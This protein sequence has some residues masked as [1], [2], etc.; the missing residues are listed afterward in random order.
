MRKL[1]LAGVAALAL[2]AAAPAALAQDNTAGAAA[3]AGTGA[4][5]GFIFGGPIGAV[6]GGFSGAVIGSSVSDAAITYA[7]NHPVDHVYV[8][9]DIDVGYK[10]SGGIKVYPIEGDE[11]HG[12]F[13][14]N[15]RVWIV[16]MATGEVVASPGY[17]V[18]EKAVA[19][20]KA[21]PTASI[22][23]SG[24]VSPGF[25]LDSGVTLADVPDAHGYAYAY[26][27]DQP[28]LVDSR[29]RIVIWVG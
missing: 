22:E 14:A 20:V 11:A 18:P 24:D 21:N 7:G 12:Y 10:V 26:I 8:D 1:L 5:L 4:T 23:I 3:G 16:D 19:Y 9:D 28:V 25:V 13:Y 27:G 6:I 17:V 29:S 2:G 15:N